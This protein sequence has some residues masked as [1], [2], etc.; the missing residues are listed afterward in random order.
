MIIGQLLLFN[1]MLLLKLYTVQSPMSS[2]IILLTMVNISGSMQFL[3]NFMPET[4]FLAQK[5]FFTSLP[6]LIFK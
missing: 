2:I 5:K 6:Q 1:Q 4:P 3:C